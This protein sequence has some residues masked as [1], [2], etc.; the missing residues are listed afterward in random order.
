MN[1][2]LRDLAGDIAAIVTSNK[3]AR[4]RSPDVIPGWFH[5]SGDTMKATVPGAIFKSVDGNTIYTI[6]FSAPVHMTAEGMKFKVVNLTTR[7]SPQL[8]D[9]EWVKANLGGALMSFF[10]GKRPGAATATPAL[11]ARIRA[12]NP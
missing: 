8:R 12:A 10:P 9:V 5:T 6:P 7:A 4:E 11:A 3:E 1:E 2:I